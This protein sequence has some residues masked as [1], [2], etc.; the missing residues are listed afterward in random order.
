MKIIVPATSVTL[1]TP[2]IRQSRNLAPFLNFGVFF[3]AILMLLAS[4]KPAHADTVS[5]NLLN[6]TMPWAMAVNPVTN[7]IYVGNTNNTVTV[8]EGAS[9]VLKTISVGAGYPALAVNPMNN[10]IYVAHRSDNTVTVIDGNSDTV[11]TTVTVGSIPVSVAINTATNQV[12]VANNGS[13]SLMVID[14][15]S[16]LVTATVAVGTKPN[17]V[18]FNPASKKIYVASGDSNSGSVTIID[19]IDNS[20]KATVATGKRPGA[21]A[22]NLATNK[23]YVAN[24]NDTTVTQID[25]A[26]NAVTATITVGTHPS[27]L[28]VN[29]LTNKVYVTNYT[30]EEINNFTVINGADNS[31]TALTVSMSPDTVAINAVTNKIYVAS[32]SGKELVVI[33]GATNVT[34][35]LPVGLTPTSHVGAYTVAV[36][37]VTNKIYAGVSNEYLITVINGVNSGVNNGAGAVPLTTTITALANNQTSST[38]PTFTLAANSS[39]SPNKAPV[40]AV[41]YQLD[42][43]QGAWLRA[44]GSGPFSAVISSLSDG[45]HTLYAYAVDGQHDSALMTGRG[46][47]PLIGKIASYAFTK[48]PATGVT[49]INF[50]AQTGVMVSTLATSNA[51]TVSGLSGS[52]AISVAGGKYAKNGAAYTTV[53]GSV[54]NGDVITLQ[55]TS[56]GNYATKTSAT[57]TIGTASGNFDVTTAVADTQPNEFLFFTWIGQAINTMTTSNTITVAGIN[58]AAPISIGSGPASAKYSINGGAYTAAAGTVKNGDSVTVQQLSSNGY[59]STVETFLTI[60]GVQGSF[61]VDTAPEPDTTPEPFSFPAK[62]GVP[63]ASLVSSA[64]I[65][66]AGINTAA[67]ISIV[68]GKY[69]ING[70]S[71]TA[72]AGTVNLDD[73]V[74][75]QLTS[76]GSAATKATATLTIGGVSGV[77]NVTTQTAGD[78]TPNAF[79][80]TAQTGVARSTAVISSVVTVGG[81]TAA[82]PISIVGG[83]YS[84]NGAAYTTAPGTVSNGNT[85]TLKLTSSAAYATLSKATLTIGG[86]SGVFNVTTAAIPA[87]VTSLNASSSRMVFRKAVKFTATVSGAAPNGKINFKDGSTSIAGCSA[88]TLVAGAASCTST[89]LTLGTHSI[90]ASYTGDA[91]HAGSSSAVLSLTVLQKLPSIVPALQLLLN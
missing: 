72:A 49:P 11:L 58:K 74:T 91:N 13:A 45:A 22:I 43:V 40:Q 80:F 87:S 62:T 37:P 10:K 61:R 7:K 38:A 63:L 57:L 55:L 47:A 81:I 16:N 71:Y 73:S 28:A 25:G 15:S 50:T 44:S 31:T 4:A 53:A 27:A 42:S 41:Y 26:S 34:Q 32:V 18:A 35:S 83:S 79:S 67:P 59:L 77:F 12:F 78:T 76:S 90:S 52:A 30:S 36:N 29:P 66:V 70:G 2:H 54:S 48:V 75:L 20:V 5:A 14:G 39:F 86:I 17:A 6:G 9:N 3:M 64:G 82:T 33:D 65:S 8:L 60:G 19:S 85:I 24:M 68:G 69:S 1:S 88:V 51:I 56:S 84:I 23:V 89:A 46:S 21:I